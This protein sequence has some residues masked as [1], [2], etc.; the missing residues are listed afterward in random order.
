MIT[1]PAFGHSENPQWPRSGTAE[2]ARVCL[3]TSSAVRDQQFS[4]TDTLTLEMMREQRVT[5]AFAY[6][7]DLFTEGYVRS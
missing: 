5:Y 6:D 2:L 4:L 1:P 7:Q 3:D